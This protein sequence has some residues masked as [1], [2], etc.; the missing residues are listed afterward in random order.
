MAAP[1]S[2][3]QNAAEIYCVLIKYRIQKKKKKGG[4]RE[5]RSY[6]SGLRPNSVS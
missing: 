4:E 1:C 3:D 2:P 5:K 6:I